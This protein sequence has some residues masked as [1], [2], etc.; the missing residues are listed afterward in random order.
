MNSEIESVLHEI[1]DVRSGF[2]IPGT[3]WDGDGCKILFEQEEDKNIRL[4]SC[5]NFEAFTEQVFIDNFE[6]YTEY[7]S[8]INKRFGTAWDSKRRQIYIR[9][10]RNDMSIAEAVTR[11]HGAMMLIA[12]LD[13]YL[14]A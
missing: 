8:K 5:E 13:W 9:F 2:I 12:A 14:Y 6:D 4:S 7:V 1:Y 10:R 11:L 3:F